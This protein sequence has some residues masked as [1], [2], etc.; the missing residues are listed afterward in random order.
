MLSQL[1]VQFDPSLEIHQPI[2]LRKWAVKLHPRQFCTYFRCFHKIVCH[3]C[4]IQRPG[5]L[6]ALLLIVLDSLTSVQHR[7]GLK[8][9]PP[10]VQQHAAGWAHITTPTRS[11]VYLK[12]FEGENFCKFR[13]FVDICASFL[14]KIW[15]RGIFWWH[16]QTIC[17]SFHLKSLFS[18]NSRQFSPAKVSRYA[19][20]LCIW[21]Y[22]GG[23]FHC[24]GKWKFS[25]TNNKTVLI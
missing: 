10:C 13:C 18:T 14:H 16:Q 11:A 20:Y 5:I 22:N 24:S 25:V 17:K 6:L 1:L 23:Y 8:M 9:W 19:G 21:T 2:Y 3:H 15:G 7:R 12:T 4:W